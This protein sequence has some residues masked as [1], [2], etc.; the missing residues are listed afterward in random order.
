[1]RITESQLRKIIREQIETL[2]TDLSAGARISEAAV[3]AKVSDVQQ[4][5]NK[6]VPGLDL[7]IDSRWGGRTEA[8]WDAF[9]DKNYKTASGQPTPEQIK[10]SWKEYGP[11]IAGGKYA[12][13]PE[14]ALKFIN[15]LSAAS[16]GTSAA[17]AAAPSAAAAAPATSTPAADTSADLSIDS[18]NQR[19]RAVRLLARLRK[20]EFDRMTDP[21]VKITKEI[22]RHLYQLLGSKNA[23]IQGL[24]IFSEYEPE[25]QKD[26]LI[27]QV[28]S[29]FSET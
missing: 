7:T 15:D 20:N 22:I 27:T 1:M 29:L 19:R 9:V 25:K 21:Q 13:T 5:L 12:G 11:K 8:A 6:N 4:A 3:V 10:Q 14:G 26:L 28:N 17:P 24:E 23:Q 16:S 2:D 18:K